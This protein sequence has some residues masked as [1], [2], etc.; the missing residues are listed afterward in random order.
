MSLWFVVCLFMHRPCVLM[1]STSIYTLV[2]LRHLVNLVFLSLMLLQREVQGQGHF[3]VCS[4]FS[5]ILSSKL[6]SDSLSDKIK[7]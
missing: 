1:C 5:G 4:V 7:K 6:A 2:A 3:R